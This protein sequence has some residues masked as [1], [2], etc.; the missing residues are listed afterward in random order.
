MAE[1]DLSEFMDGFVGEASE[2][3][4]RCRRSL[5]AMAD[6]LSAGGS[7]PAEA[8]VL[9]RALHTIKGLAAMVSVEPIVQLTHAMEN[10]L[11]D[12]Q[13]AAG[14]LPE[15]AVQ[16]L[17][18]GLDAV[19]RALDTL[20]RGGTPAAPP[21]DL[22]RSLEGIEIDAA[23]DATRMQITLT[24]EEAIVAKI[25]PSDR[26]QLEAA[27]RE[28]R[29]AYQVCFSPSPARLAAGLGIT[30]L[31][32]RLEEHGQIVRVLPRPV[33]RTDDTPGGLMFVLLVVTD[34][35]RAALAEAS[36]VDLDEILPAGERARAE[37]PRE[38]DEADRGGSLDEGVVRVSVD[39]LDAAMTCLSQLLVARSRVDRAIDA[40]ELDSVALRELAR[41]RGAEQRHVRDLRQAI[42]SVRMVPM[43]ELLES[44]PLIVRGME[45]MTQKRVRLERSGAGVEVDKDVAT[46][47]YPALI[48]LLRNA[49][50]HGIESPADRVSQGKPQEG[51]VFVR[52]SRTSAG[53][54]QVE[55]GDDGGGIDPHVAARR[56]GVQLPRSERELLAILCRPGF[57][58]RAAASTTSGRGMG[59]DVVAEAVR[60]LGGSLTL[61]N[62]HGR[63]TTFTI[64]VPLTLRIVESLVFRA[65]E[66]TYVAPV[67]AIDEVYSMEGAR[68]LE[69]PAS[70]RSSAVRM[71]ERRGRAISYAPLA[72][73]L[74][75]TSAEH[76]AAPSA[77]AI[78]VRHGGSPTAF[79]IDRLT[80]RREVVVKR[81]SDAL[82]D[83]PGLS[84]STDL[85][86]GRPTL[87]LDLP[88]LAERMGAGLLTSRGG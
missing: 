12:V 60:E 46:R 68:L 34:L 49:I 85:G 9:F 24:L 79:G 31:R 56:A 7:D 45:S 18:E 75:I 37:A 52:C 84:G 4:R 14:A 43:S 87:V 65:A 13:Q 62:V 66:Q 88:A 26:A 80:G 44:M 57:S 76:A 47:L 70:G 20:R 40:L 25:T 81:L 33:P 22:L 38:R 41:E 11:R 71:M 5:E 3:V 78:V 48:H 50:D 2:H 67:S 30:V 82:V 74:G 8:R 35:P 42:L 59:M 32:Q 83:L 6:A 54:L 1:V 19:E 63:G 15:Q 21:V 28:G 16:P 73:V 29:N 77:Q 86:D 39:R 58:T 51:H 53:Q 69:P 64:R 36:G 72:S 55:V 23:T 61:H 17:E 10:V 27:I